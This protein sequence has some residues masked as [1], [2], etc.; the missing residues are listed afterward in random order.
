MPYLTP[1]FEDP[2]L[3]QG[4]RAAPWRNLRKK[5]T[6]S[7]ELLL[8]HNPCWSLL[9]A[10]LV[11]EGWGSFHLTSAVR[12]NQA[13]GI[14][15]PNKTSACTPFIVKHWAADSSR[16]QVISSLSHTWMDVSP[17][18]CLFLSTRVKESTWMMSVNFSNQIICQSWCSLSD[19]N[20]EN[21]CTKN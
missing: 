1:L 2:D 16:E 8:K 14:R 21:I 12:W 19:S 18:S 17:W 20:T 9:L 15:N 10:Y 11:H 3:F 4:S 7:C 5:R 6:L 13:S